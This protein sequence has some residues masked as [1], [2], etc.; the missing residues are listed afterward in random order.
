MIHTIETRLTLNETQE[1]F[2]DS[3]VILWSTYYR[4]TWKLWNNQQLKENEIYHQ[5]M[6][7]NLFTSRQI[8]S[9]INKVKAEHAKIKELSKT[10]LKQQKNKLLNIEKFIATEEK[11]IS[12]LFD[13][14]NNLKL[15]LKN[16]HNTT[17]AIFKEPKTKESKLKLHERLSKLTHSIKKKNLVL[18]NKKIKL[19]R[20]K[21]S[22]KVLEQRIKFNKFKLCFG[23]SQLLKQRPGSF[24][25]QFR[26]TKEQNKYKNKDINVNL[27]AWE[28]DWDLARNNIWISIGDKNKSHGNAE[29]QYDPHTKTLKLRL[30]EQTA[31]ERLKEIA[32]NINIPYE[33][34]NSNQ[35]I[36]YGIYRMQARFMEIPGVEFCPKN[37][38]KIQQAIVNQQPI[39]AK[40][41][42]KLTP[43]GKGI[44]YYLQLS[45]EEILINN[46]LV[47][48]NNQNILKEKLTMGIDLN[49][50]G[51]AYC[52]IK[53]D[54]NKLSP[55]DQKNNS[56]Q[57][58]PCG[59][60]QWDLKDKTTAQRQW[61]ISNKITE[62]LTIA[63]DYHIKNISIENLDFISTVN[64]MNSGYKG[65]TN[66]KGFNY[67]KMLT[68]FAKRQFGDMIGRKTE[69]LGMNLYLVNPAYSS[70]GGFSKYGIVNKLPVDMAASLWLARQAI[71]GEVYKEEVRNNINN[72]SYIRY[73]KKYK[74][75]VV[76]P[77]D[78]LSK[79]SKRE[80]QSKKEWNTIALALGKNR[81][82]WYKNY[83]KY[84]KTMNEGVN[85]KVGKTL[86]LPKELFNHE[87]DPFAINPS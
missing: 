12:K 39:T 70:V 63:E 68:N 44:G 22:I 86:L 53:T 48:K 64:N 34:L 67:N 9:L 43:N 13:E 31:N 72:I 49:E 6:T 78:N 85:P 25:D 2:V 26:L 80:I 33:E 41:I 18:F 24:T 38:V 83:M 62:L 69:R 57:Y 21:R 27:A 82:S 59:F 42:K 71:Y 30:T 61:V 52:I 1:F 17:K 56:L 23:S 47:N 3:C 54:G 20:L 75:A 66:D 46:N 60:I 15:K 10:Q 55:R 11:N 45:F 36:K 87:Y 5:L 28:K 50:K 32:K 7:L 79:Q 8:S 81:N 74:E 73:V 77:Y 84:I 19:N 14:I 51:L 16:Y 65:K 58:K 29:I 35:N 4:K 76:F 37:Q 40:I